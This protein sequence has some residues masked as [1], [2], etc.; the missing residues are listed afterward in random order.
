VSSDAAQAIASDRVWTAE[1][2]L[3]AAVAILP[4]TLTPLPLLP[5]DGGIDGVTAVGSSIEVE[6][7]GWF[8]VLMRVEWDPTNRAGHR[9]AHTA[10]ADGHP[11]HSEAI[12]AEVLAEL[13]GGRQLLRGNTL[14]RPGRVD[15]LT[16]EVWQ[17]TVVPV[18][19]CAAALELRFLGAAPT[20]SD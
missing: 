6:I 7:E 1:H 13:N 10:L 2:E 16:L 4:R 11:L 5:V 3:G 19:V 12:E 9:F 20:I 17:D 14:F 8:E 15:R 18:T